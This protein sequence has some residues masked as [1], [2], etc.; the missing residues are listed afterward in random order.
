MLSNRPYG[1][2]RMRVETADTH[3]ATISVRVPTEMPWGVAV[4]GRVA[5]LNCL[6]S[7]MRE[8]THM[9]IVEGDT[10]GI[11]PGDY[12]TVN[13]VCILTFRTSVS[14]LK[15]LLVGPLDI[16]DAGHEKVD[17]TLINVAELISYGI[18]WFVDEAGNPVTE[19]VGGRRV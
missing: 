2:L 3:K 13:D 18:S 12:V 11:T 1:R 5:I 6:G 8:F 9:P 10:E 16:F 15:L 17:A 4:A 19:Y 14:T 7:A